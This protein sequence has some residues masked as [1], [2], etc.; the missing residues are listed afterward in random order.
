MVI[1]ILHHSHQRNVLLVDFILNLEMVHQGT[2]IIK[3]PLKFLGA[4]EIS[5]DNFY[6]FVGIFVFLFIGLILKK[7]L[8]VEG[9]TLLLDRAE[10]L[11]VKSHPVPQL[12]LQSIYILFRILQ[13]YFDL[14]RHSRSKLIEITANNLQN[15]FLIY[16]VGHLYLIILISEVSIELQL[17]VISLSLLISEVIDVDTHR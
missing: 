8:G 11:L 12:L 17:I 5:F 15:L 9:F 13:L 2:E 3:E 7:L 14:L 1:V 4:V 10:L 16:L 6:L